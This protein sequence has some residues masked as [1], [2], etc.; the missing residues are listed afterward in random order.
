MQKRYLY[1]KDKL[2]K[3]MKEYMIFLIFYLIC[4]ILTVTIEA[5]LEFKIVVYILLFLWTI[6][7]VSDCIFSSGFDRIII[8][9]KGYTIFCKSIPQIVHWNQVH[10]IRWGYKYQ[11]KLDNT[12]KKQIVVERISSKGKEVLDYIPGDDALYNIMSEYIDK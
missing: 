4:F 10:N 7:F 5:L 3:G 8:R 1:N 12:L 2:I 6:V 11:D 9:Q